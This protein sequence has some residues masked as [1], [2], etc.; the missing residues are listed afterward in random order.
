MDYSSNAAPKFGGT[1]TLTG[2]LLS[3]VANSST[4]VTESASNTTNINAGQTDVVATS[5]GGGTFTLALNIIVRPTGGGGTIDVSTGSGSPTFSVTTSASNT[6]GLLGAGPAFAT[7]SSGATWATAS[8]GNIAGLSASGYGPNT[9]TTNTNVDV[10]A[11]AGLHEVRL[12]QDTCL[13]TT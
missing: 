10:T 2:G 12:K 6:N 1:I 7:V 5:P 4:P 3:L 11:S 13:G 9:F 8:G